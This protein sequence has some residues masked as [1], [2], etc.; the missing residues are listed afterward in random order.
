VA[1]ELRQRHAEFFLAL[2]EATEPS[3]VGVGSRKE[4]LEPLEREH[5]NLRAAMDW[6]E[7][8]GDGDRVIRFA[9]ALWRFWH[10]TGHLKEGRLRV[11]GALGVGT[12]PSSARA[13]ALSGAADMA[14][15][16]GDVPTGGRWAREALELHR[17]LGDD[18]GTAFSTLMVAYATGQEGDW[19]RAQQLFGDSTRRFRELGDR[20][21][22]LRGARAQA[23]AYREGGDLESAWVLCEA[24]IPEARATGDALAE[25][26][27][28]RGLADIALDRGD[29]QDAASL[30]EEGYA[31]FRGLEDQLLIAAGVCQFSRVLG[32]AG[33]PRAATR[34]LS[35]S[36]A[37]LEEIGA[38]PPWVARM[39]EETLATVRRELDEAAFAEAWQ[40]G[41]E[42][43]ADQA[44]ELAL[45]VLGDA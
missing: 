8:S 10:L 24:I 41:G 16:S 39:V 42:L 38:M 17:D 7:A 26:Y 9:A 3:L 5:D 6:F 12:R 43:T 29:V 15:T 35:S 20:H 28:L 40:E 45:A 13:K 25:G 11:E 19:V 27:A 36:V 34:V 44:V 22:A 4:W 2:A 30:T 31:L 14:L 33:R 1:D 21:Y 18:W 37:L 32:L 23:W